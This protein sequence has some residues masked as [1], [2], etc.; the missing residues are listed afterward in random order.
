VRTRTAIKEPVAIDTMT[1][2]YL[3]S[4]DLEDFGEIFLSRFRICEWWFDLG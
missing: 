1:L 2:V 3:S 4:A